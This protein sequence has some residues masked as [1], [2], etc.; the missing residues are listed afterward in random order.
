MFWRKAHS[1]RVVRV[2]AKNREQDLDR[3]LR[4]HLE[5]EAEEQTDRR[6]LGNVGFIKEDVRQA[7]GWT[8][9]D[10]LWQ[11]LRYGCRTLRKSPAFAATAVLSL[12]L[13]IGASTAIFSLID[14]LLLRWLPVRDPQELLQLTIAGNP[15]AVPPLMENFPIR[16]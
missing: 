7:W 2:K 9:L 3:E 5:L 16:S 4:A 6:A 12:A 10:R 14:A 1:E 15:R 8:W 13:G 11:D